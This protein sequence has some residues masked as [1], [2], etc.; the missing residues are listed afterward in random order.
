MEQVYPGIY[1]VEISCSVCEHCVQ[2][3]VHFHRK[4]EFPH[5]FHPISIH[6]IIVK[7][8]MKYND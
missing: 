2:G 8:S 1:A 7:V 5:S 3:T 6:K 4:V